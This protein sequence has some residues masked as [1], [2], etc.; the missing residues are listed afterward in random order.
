LADTWA[1]ALLLLPK[2]EEFVRRLDVS[3]NFLVLQHRLDT[4]PIF[5]RFLT[6]EGLF[7]GALA[8]THS[9]S[10]AV[11]FV[12]LAESFRIFGNDADKL[13]KLCLELLVAIEVK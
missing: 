11:S 4:L 1:I 8:R 9:S 12:V 10:L 6:S 7:R 3:R 5:K 2:V 13:I